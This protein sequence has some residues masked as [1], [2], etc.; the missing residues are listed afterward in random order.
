MI[1]GGIGALVLALIGSYIGINP[2]ILK[3][4]LG[5]VVGPQQVQQGPAP[6]DGYKEFAEKVLGSCDAVWRDQFAKLENGWGNKKYDKP[7][8]KLFSEGVNTK[9]CGAAH[10]AVGPFYCP[11]D[12]HVYLDP[13]FFDELQNK[14]KGSK[15]EFS[16]AF[17]IAH[18]VGHHV[19]NI[20]GYNAMLERYRQMEGENAGIRL[21][22]Q[23]D[24]LAGV[25][26]H[27]AHKKF[28]L[29]TDKKDID[30]ALQSAQAIGDDILQKRFNGRVDPKS[31][32][33]GTANQRSYFFQRGLETGDFR[34]STLDKFF[35]RNIRPL[36]L[37]SRSGI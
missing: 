8:M 18:E 19:Q 13:T 36:D 17:V 24:Y 25:W 27:H 14:L 26:A 5:P 32:N 10:S 15:A 11:A 34:K 30:S 7:T 33:H 21:E 4:L 37:G 16:Q 3:G 6:Q 20:T 1:G 9:G 29:I 23:A 35:D 2:D 31:F 12:R 22:L 28:N